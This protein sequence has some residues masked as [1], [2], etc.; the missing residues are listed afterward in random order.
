[1]AVERCGKLIVANGEGQLAVLHVLLKAG[2][3]NGVLDLELVG[4]EA[5]RCST[6]ELRATNALVSPSTG[7]VDSHALMLA[8]LG[9]AAANDAEL[10]LG[11]DVS[12]FTR[13]RDGWALHLSGVDRP[14]LTARSIVNAAGLSAPSLA[15]QFAGF[16]PEKAIQGHLA[17]G[18]YFS[19]AG[20]TPFTQLI[21]P[22]PEPGG[23]GIH[24]TL[25][26]ARRARFGPNVEWVDDLD[27]RVDHALRPLFAKAIRS[28]WPDVDESRLAPDYAGI[29]PKIVGPGEPAADFVIQTS[30]QHG[31][32]GVINL[33]GIESP[34]LTASLALADL[35]V[36]NLLAG[37]T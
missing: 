15:R 37:R 1:V 20:R 2:K 29:R 5:L 19:Y 17:K 14:V 7:I 26:L 30:A 24:L 12:H 33:L 21:Y 25:D 31:L 36:E 13:H 23:L 11:Q 18:N 34:G 27:Y 22:V 16:P 8:Y 4:P 35:V 6:P 9:E 28:Y 3:A 32:D 10:V